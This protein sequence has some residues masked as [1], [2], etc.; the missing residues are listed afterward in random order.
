MRP[1]TAL[2]L[3]WLVGLATILS[4]VPS[5][6]NACEACNAALTKRL[7]GGPTPSKHAEELTDL[8]KRSGW[9]GS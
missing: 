1:H 4:L 5:P 9:S 3:A 6:A 8:V 7:I 2:S